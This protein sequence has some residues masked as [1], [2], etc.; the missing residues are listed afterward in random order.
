VIINVSYDSSVTDLN[1]P[2]NAAYNPTLYQGYTSAVRQA[3]QFYENEFTNPVTA[4]I[5]FGWG[6]V[7]A[8]PLTGLGSSIGRSQTAGSTYTYSQLYNAVRATDTTSAVQLA[9]AASLPATDPTG[10]APF[11]VVDPE[12]EA[13]GLTGSGTAREEY[14]GLNNSYSYTWSQ[15]A[16][17]PGT[18]D[19]VGVLEHEISEDLGRTAHVPPNNDYRLLN[20]FRYTAADGSATDVPGSPAGVLD[21]P[22]MPGYDPNAYSYFS[23]DG[24][25]VTL[26]YDTPAQV[27]AG[28]DMA[29]WTN[30][31]NNDSY[32]GAQAGQLNAVSATDLEEMNVLGYDLTGSGLLGGLSVSQQLQLIYIAYFNR[33]ADGAGF[34]YW[35]GQSATTTLNNIA[36]AFAPQSETIALYPFLGTAN[37]NLSTPTAQTGLTTFINSV[38]QNM[39]GHAPDPTGGAYWLG[40]ITGGAVGL[41]AAALSIGNGATGADATEL[42]NKI[43]VSLDFTTRTQ[44]ADLGLTNIPASFLTIAH[45]VLSKVDGTALNDA[46]VT[47]G[48][49]DT[50]AYISSAKPGSVTAAETADS[51]APVIP[52][53]PVVIS[54]SNSVIDPGAGGYSIQFL[55]GV[56]D[57]TLMLHTDGV[58]QVS[59]FDVSTDV[60]NVSALLRESNVNLNGDVLDLSNYLSITDQSGNAFVNFD[61]TG[62]GGGS[63]TVAVLQGLGGVL[64]GLGQLLGQ[65]AIRIA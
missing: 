50:T 65:G 53:D 32:G 11:L 17:A 21:E 33:A 22:F 35:I 42:Q 43:T 6:E 4:N 29:D 46:S 24:K 55:A 39:F 25:T 12:A 57:D 23:Y 7:E 18:V 8:T 64:T 40:Q 54:A 61:P 47:A 56:N 20:M 13:L 14:V 51:S 48:E 30:T 2:G 5:S 15:P 34:N 28:D 59:G 58:D 10:G 49:S 63:S 26:P 60:L 1:T 27:A 52:I 62:Q 9:A 44:A 31:V 41:G 16:I 36:N 19:A 3:V 45:S 37:L 38:Y